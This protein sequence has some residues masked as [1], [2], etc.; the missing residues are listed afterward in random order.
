MNAKRKQSGLTLT[1]MVVV[2]GVIALLTGLALPAVRM[3]MQS[4]ES[5]SSATSMISSALAAARA[6]AARDGEYVGVRFQKVYNSDSIDPLNPLKASQYMI[7]IIHDSDRIPKGTG[8]AN[9]FRAIEGHKPIKLPD[10]I[11]VMDLTWVDR[12]VAGNIITFTGYPIRTDAEI[13]S[14]EQLRDTTTFS[15]IFSPSGRLLTHEV[16]VRNR[17]G[18]TNGVVTQSLDDVFNTDVQITNLTAPYGMFHQDDYPPVGPMGIGPE[19]SRNKFLIYDRLRLRKA[20]EAGL[21]WSDYLVNLAGE[22]TYINP[23]TGTIILRN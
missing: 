11:G 1:E 10:S 13:S 9:G 17:N 21:A 12:T 19:W 6:L 14:P 20:F 22:M 2:V 16:R 18:R 7:F 4:F 23:H 15:I 5:G 8:L 3:V